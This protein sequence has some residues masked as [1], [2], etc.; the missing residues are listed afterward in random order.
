MELLSVAVK[1]L[2]A[3]LLFI[4]NYLLLLTC[5]NSKVSILMLFLFKVFATIEC[6]TEKKAIISQTK[7][8]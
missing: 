8:E 4:P 2:D 7:N 6:D 3:I 1:V 5:K